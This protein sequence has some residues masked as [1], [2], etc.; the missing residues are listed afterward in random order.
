M[1]EW[2]KKFIKLNDGLCEE[3]RNTE[4]KFPDADKSC[5]S[6]I[7]I[8][9]LEKDVEKHGSTEAKKIMK[10]YKKQMEGAML[11]KNTNKSKTNDEVQK[12]LSSKV[13]GSKTNDEVQKIL[14]SKVNSK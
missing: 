4:I 5:Y 1:E 9:K 10:E 6:T 3:I 8:D 7:D 14:S 12:I 13:N 2:M 11:N